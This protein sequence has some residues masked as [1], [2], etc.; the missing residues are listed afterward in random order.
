MLSIEV[1]VAPL[2]PCHV[3]IAPAWQERGMVSKSIWLEMWEKYSSLY[4]GRNAV[5][6]F[7]IDSNVVCEGPQLSLVD[8]N[9][10]SF[11]QVLGLFN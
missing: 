7:H 11:C 4:F 9:A 10:L 3:G 6:E 8:I 1:A 2:P 5:S